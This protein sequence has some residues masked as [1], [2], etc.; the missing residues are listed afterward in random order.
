[1]FLSANTS[2]IFL[3]PLIL[4]ALCAR[5]IKGFRK[6]AIMLK[7]RV[8]KQASGVRPSLGAHPTP[9]SFIYDYP[10]RITYEIKPGIFEEKRGI[11]ALL[12]KNSRFYLIFDP[13]DPL[14]YF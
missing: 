9:A 12:F 8:I 7:Y 6:M 3:K 11:A 4:R 1:M 10:L 2:A 5:K 14:T 13:Y